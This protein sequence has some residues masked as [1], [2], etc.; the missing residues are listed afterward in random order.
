MDEGHHL[1]ENF[2]S[3]NVSIVSIPEVNVLGLDCYLLSAPSD[4]LEHLGQASSCHWLWVK[5][6]EQLRWWTPKVLFK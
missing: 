3:P 2:D 1:Q 4:G 5:T 6:L